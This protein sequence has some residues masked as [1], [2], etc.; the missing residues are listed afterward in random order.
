[1][2]ESPVMSVK[3]VRLV[4]YPFVSQDSYE[5]APG[6]SNVIWNPFQTALSVSRLDV[7]W[8]CLARALINSLTCLY[9]LLLSA[10]R[11]SLIS[12]RCPS[13]SW[14]KARVSLLHS[15]GGVRNSAPRERR[16]S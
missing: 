6:M 2:N 12:R 16:T 15:K 11:T 13:G 4:K 10:S 14:K 5:A 7:G 8:S 1:V 9:S 3:T